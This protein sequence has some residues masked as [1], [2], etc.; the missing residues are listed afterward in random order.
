MTSTRKLKL[1]SNAETCAAAAAAVN[2]AVRAP[3]TRRAIWVYSYDALYVVVDPDFPS[4]DGTATF[5]FDSHWN[6]I[7][8]FGFYHF[9]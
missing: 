7:I 5:F 4:D 1:L 3:D 2:S 6:E 8:G 9:P